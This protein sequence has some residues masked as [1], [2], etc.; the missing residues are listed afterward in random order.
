VVA[1]TPPA[2]ET[3][4]K[5]PPPPSE[6]SPVEV[7]ATKKARAELAAKVKDLEKALKE[8]DA[9]H[10]Q[11]L[12]GLDV[13][14]LRRSY[15]Q[16]IVDARRKE[17]ELEHLLQREQELK[18]FAES[19]ARGKLKEL[20]DQ[21]AEIESRQRTIQ[22]AWRQS[23]EED[24][25]GKVDEPAKKDLETIRAVKA[26]WFAAT[27]QARRGAAKESE[28]KII[29]DGFRAWLGEVADRKRVVTDTLALR[30]AP[31]GKTP[32]NYDFTDLKFFVLLELMEEQMERK[33]IAIER[34]ELSESR[35]KLEAIQKELDG[36][37]EKIRDQ[38][39]AAGEEF[40]E[41]EDLLERKEP[42][43]KSASY[44]ST[45]V[46]ELNAILKQVDEI[47]ERQSREQN[48]AEAALESARKALR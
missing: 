15:T 1:K 17:N 45:R 16:A 44:L 6:P 7:E 29:S 2:T 42:L 8:M 12:K 21:R 22:D 38:M 24:S 48:E 19:A 25:Q 41:Y 10:A 46:Q 23:A 39:T 26:Q 11:E 35:A 27:P 13:V 14:Q 32:D 18:R 37:D 33:N 36:V 40:Q 3:Q 34:K 9:R 20:R 30:E 5:P 43:Q 28:R 47:K 4:V 31:K